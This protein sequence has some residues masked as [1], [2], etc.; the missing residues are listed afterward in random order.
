MEKI[1]TIKI[2]TPD[3]ERETFLYF[4]SLLNDVTFAYRLKVK[5]SNETIKYG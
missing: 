3:T 4:Q 2:N 5:G 1:I